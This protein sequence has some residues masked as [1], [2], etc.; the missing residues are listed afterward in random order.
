MA[1]K[2][3]Q[4]AAATREHILDTAERVF[5]EHGVSRTSLA[6]I[7]DAAGVTRGAIYWHFRNKGDLFTALLDRV[8]LPMEEMVA[9][10][11]DD[12]A[13]DPLSSIRA[14]CVYVL[15][16]T[17]RDTQCRRVFE[18]LA[19]KCEYVDEM[20]PLVARHMQCR[21]QGI[22][23]I[24]RALRNAMRKGQLPRHLQV[25]RA[26]VGLHAYVD[27]LIYNW[28]LDPRS[29]ALDQDAEAL[30]D[31]YLQGLKS[32][33]APRRSAARSL[34]PKPNTTAQR[35]TEKIERE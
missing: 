8:A 32:V 9:Q 24:E 11:A 33:P 5:S 25:R 12:H 23:M 30:V 2:T 21:S 27:G 6:Y 15:R 10:A 35:T 14:C 19:H 7:A 31:Q 18:I 3:K 20:H 28:L 13:A 34:H 29:F 16:R 4:E 17:V 26:A 22:G 1:R